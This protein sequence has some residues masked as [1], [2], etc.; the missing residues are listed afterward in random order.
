MA[1][2]TRQAT[3]TTKGPSHR[4]RQKEQKEPRNIPS[5][6]AAAAAGLFLK[7]PPS[8]HAKKKEPLPS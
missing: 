8:L 4:H 2:G 7:L 1:V 5:A 6:A 3:K